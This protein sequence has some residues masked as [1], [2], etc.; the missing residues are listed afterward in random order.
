[1]Y[2]E[3]KIIPVKYTKFKVLPPEAKNPNEIFIFGDI[4]TEFFFAGGM[5]T[6]ILIDNKEITDNY[7]DYFNF[8]WK[9]IK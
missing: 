6:A 5:F 8:L 3:E 2:E 9:I 7:R 4:T 1:M